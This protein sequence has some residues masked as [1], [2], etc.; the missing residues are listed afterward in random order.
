MKLICPH[1]E[2]D[3]EH[4]NET[5]ECDDTKRADD[6][7]AYTGDSVLACWGYDPPDKDKAAG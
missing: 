1:S 3:C 2:G 7:L 4:K 5:G 6:D